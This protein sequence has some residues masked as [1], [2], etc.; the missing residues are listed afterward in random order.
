MDTYSRIHIVSDLES[1]A[2]CTLQ[3]TVGLSF[4]SHLATG[5]YDKHVYTQSLKCKAMHAVMNNCTIPT[6]TF[7]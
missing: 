5:D 4:K 1:T 6:N 3:Y 7:L 2:R